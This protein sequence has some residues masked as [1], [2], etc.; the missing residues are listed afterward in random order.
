MAQNMAQIQISDMAQTE[1]KSKGRKV[2]HFCPGCSSW[3]N[4]G[5]FQ[6]KNRKPAAYAMCDQCLAKKKG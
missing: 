3:L 1:R 5:H 4:D 2:W 6:E